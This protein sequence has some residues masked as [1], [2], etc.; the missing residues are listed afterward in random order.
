MRWGYQLF[1]RPLR[2]LVFQWGRDCDA[3]HRSKNQTAPRVP[4]DS[5]HTQMVSRHLRTCASLLVSQLHRDLPQPCSRAG[6]LPQGALEVSGRILGWSQSWG[7]AGSHTL[8]VLRDPEQLPNRSGSAVHVTWNVPPPQH[9]SHPC[10]PTTSLTQNSIPCHFATGS[11]FLLV[12]IRAEFSR[13]TTASKMRGNTFFFFSVW[14]IS[15][16]SFNSLGTYVS[17]TQRR[18]CQLLGCCPPTEL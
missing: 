13:S 7:A 5:S 8:R 14:S 11:I 12:W 15:Q 10:R 4:K 16:E 3:H 18:L 1:T 9:P 6:T 2:S 17:H